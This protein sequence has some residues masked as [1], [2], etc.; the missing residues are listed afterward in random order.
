MSKQ[1]WEAPF[2]YLMGVPGTFG[3]MSKMVNEMGH[4]TAVTA[5]NRVTAYCHDG[6]GIGL[7]NAGFTMVNI[8]GGM[9]G[10]VPALIKSQTTCS[11][12]GTRPGT[13]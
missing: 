4:V 3:G 13:S 11:G 12:N 6:Y 7:S 1:A 9:S 2:L 5:G 8:V 10:Q